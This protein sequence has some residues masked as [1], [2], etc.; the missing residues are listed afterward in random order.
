M[1]ESSP[2]MP[3]V[4]FP[5]VHCLYVAL[6]KEGRMSQRRPPL[7][8]KTETHWVPSPNTLI[9]DNGILDLHILL[10]DPGAVALTPHSPL[11]VST[12]ALPFAF[13]ASAECPRWQTCTLEPSSTFPV[14]SK[15]SIDPKALTYPAFEALLMGLSQASA[16][17]IFELAR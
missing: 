16:S 9:V 11:L 5:A 14:I 15:P 10:N 6:Q 12:I 3:F 2:R 1:T 7:I 13:D 4:M 17:A 8:L